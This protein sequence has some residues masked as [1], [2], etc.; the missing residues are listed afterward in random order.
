M[1]ALLPTVKDFVSIE[2]KLFDKV[3]TIGLDVSQHEYKR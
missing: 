3:S 1:K 2:S